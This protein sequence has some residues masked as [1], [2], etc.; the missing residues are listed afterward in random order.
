MSVAK[1]TGVFGFV[2][3]VK[4]KKKNARGLGETLLG[5]VLGPELVT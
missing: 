5:R 1:Y 3:L 2:P 4:E